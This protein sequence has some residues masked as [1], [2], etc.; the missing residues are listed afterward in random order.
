M[1]RVPCSFVEV[2]FVRAERKTRAKRKDERKK[3]R[4]EHKK[5]EHG[6]NRKIIHTLASLCLSYA[7]LAKD[8]KYLG[9]RLPALLEHQ[10]R[11][12]H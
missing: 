9:I 2:Y 3:K 8:K 10:G 5:I 7:P 12:K 6:E 4:N 11:H 1:E